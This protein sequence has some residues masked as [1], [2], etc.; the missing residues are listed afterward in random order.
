MEKKQLFYL[1]LIT[2]LL[3]VI[4]LALVVLT[5]FLGKTVRTVESFSPQISSILSNIDT[6]SEA[7][8]Q[9]DTESILSAVNELSVNLQKVDWSA[10]DTMTTDA[11]K[12]LALAGEALEKTIKAIDALDIETLNKAIGDLRTVVEPLANL[13]ERFR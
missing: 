7:L 2:V 6:V 13:V 3:A 11:Q 10:I 4:V 8:E 5:V 1:R 9:A 12:S